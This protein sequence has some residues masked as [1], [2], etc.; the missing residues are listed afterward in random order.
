MHLESYRGREIA[1][2]LHPLAALRIQVFR[3]WPYL[4]DGSESYE[5]SYLQT[6]VQCPDSIVG[7]VWDGD[8]AVGATTALPFSAAQMGEHLQQPL[9]DAESLYYL[10][11]SVILP[12]Y[13][14]QGWGVKFFDLREAEGQRLG[15]GIA[16]FC[17][18]ERPED[19]PLKPTNYTGN[20]AFWHKRGYQRNAD[21]RCTFSWLDVDQREESA[22]TLVFWRKSL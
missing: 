19:H 22:K 15:Y 5:Q 6:Y 18:V 20:A 10:G 2:V 17:A 8:T 1:G 11:E 7:V 21:Q 9:P 16:S 3:E 14:G 12:A 4:Y 13:R